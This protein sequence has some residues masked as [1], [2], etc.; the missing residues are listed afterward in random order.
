MAAEAASDPGIIPTATAV[1]LL[2]LPSESDLKAL[3]RKGWFKPVSPGRWR[4]VDV[5]QGYSRYLQDRAAAA[6][7]AAAEATARPGRGQPSPYSDEHCATALKLTRQGATDAELAEEFGVSRRTILTWRAEHPEFADACRLGKEEADDRVEAS[8]YQRAC[9]YE[10]EAVRI[11]YDR[12]TGKIVYAPYTEHIPADPVA[13]LMWLKNRRSKKWRDRHELTGADGGPVQFEEVDPGVELLRRIA[14]IADR[15]GV[16]AQ[17]PLLAG[18]A[19]GE[20]AG[21]DGAGVLLD[22]VAGPAECAPVGLA[23]L[24]E[25]EAADPAG[26]L[27]DMVAACR[28]RIRQE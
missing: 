26:E 27:V 5:V 2:Q 28:E 8:L 3:A 4:V 10:Y 17:G 6:E 1:A 20:G 19:S 15:G 11:F 23:V 12:E 16:G 14:A 9:G 22:A 24:G 18:G 7:A 13:G 21:G 25:A